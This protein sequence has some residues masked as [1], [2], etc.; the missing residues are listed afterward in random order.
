MRKYM[1]RIVVGGIQKNIGGMKM[2]KNS[3]VAL[4]DMNRAELRYE[5]VRCKKEFQV[6]LS[7]YEFTQADEMKKRIKEI[8]QK[9]QDAL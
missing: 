2:G 1:T 8:E 7:R 3:V 5:M 6:A 4:C 9:L